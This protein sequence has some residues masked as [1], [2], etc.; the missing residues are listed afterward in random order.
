MESIKAKYYVYTILTEQFVLY[1]Y[2]L[3]DYNYHKYNPEF[4]VW[5]KLF[6]QERDVSCQITPQVFEYL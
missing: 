6:M 4:I 2:Y 5:C 3:Q 1:I